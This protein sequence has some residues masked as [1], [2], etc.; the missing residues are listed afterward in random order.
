MSK[1][2]GAYYFSHD[3]NAR[4]DEKL[5]AVRMKLGVEGYGIYFMILERLL[6]ATDYMSIKD[7]NIIAFDL[8]VSAEKVKSVIEDFG[9]FNFTDDGKKFFS[10]SFLNRMKPLDNMREQRSQAGKKSAEKRAKSND[11]ST[12]V[13]R[14]L[15]ENPTK[16]R[17]GEESK[18]NTTYVV[19][20]EEY[21]EKIK[22]FLLRQK[23][24]IDLLAM[25]YKTSAET[26]IE[27]INLFVE[28]SVHGDKIWTDENDSW[29]HFTNWFP[30]N[31]KTNVVNPFKTWNAKQFGD[32][33]KNVPGIPNAVKQE[34]YDYYSQTAENGFM[35]FQNFDA[36]ET[37]KQLKSWKRKNQRKIS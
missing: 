28:F 7:Y 32:E 18:V 8:R 17:K 24:K 31:I 36:W 9:L 20:E 10:E 4:N 1:A 13:E 30:K 34:F 26:V 5:I 23:A 29:V 11:N 33:V 12:T 6:E 22:T 25:R 15:P 35:R 14:P 16:E 27:K 19:V 37:E 2:K 3:S 21:Y